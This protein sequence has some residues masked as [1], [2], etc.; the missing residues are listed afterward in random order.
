MYVKRAG[1]ETC[2]TRFKSLQR[3]CLD[4]TADDTSPYGVDPAF[5]RGSSFYSPDYDERAA[6]RLYN[7]SEE[8]GAAATYDD[9]GRGLH[10]STFQLNL[11]RF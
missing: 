2:D 9:A 5:K 1:T 10:S 7:C 4:I 8:V 3:S 6:A 11:S